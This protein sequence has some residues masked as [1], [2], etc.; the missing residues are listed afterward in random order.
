MIRL[1]VYVSKP[2][3]GNEMDTM[4]AADAPVTHNTRN[5][6]RING[7]VLEDWTA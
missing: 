7:L 2:D 6:E 5:F 1:V 3:D 4:I